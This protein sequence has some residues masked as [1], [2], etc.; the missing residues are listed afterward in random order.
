M[1]K[2]EFIIRRHYHTFILDSKVEQLPQHST[3]FHK[4]KKFSRIFQLK[5]FFQREGNTHRT[6]YSAALGTV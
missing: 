1:R 2:I 4:L 5:D 3:E 6:L